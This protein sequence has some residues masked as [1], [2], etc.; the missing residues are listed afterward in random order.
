MSVVS[1][2]EVVKVRLVDKGVSP[3]MVPVSQVCGERW[4]EKYIVYIT[5]PRRANVPAL[6][7]ANRAVRALIKHRMLSTNEEPV[8]GV[9]EPMTLRQATP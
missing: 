3:S 7:V 8:L 9:P 6:Q 5:A 4:N 2:V 1:P